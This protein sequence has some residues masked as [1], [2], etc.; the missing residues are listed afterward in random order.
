MSLPQNNIFFKGDTI[1]LE[2]QLFRDE[3]KKEYWNLTNHEIRFQLDSSPAIKKAT[4][5]VVGGS[6]EQIRILD[7][8]KGVF[9]VVITK[10][11]SENLSPKD[12]NFEIEITTPSGARYTVLQS[13]L[14]ILQDIVTWENK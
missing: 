3:E 1:E 2:F 4:A 8:L 5:N 13:S 9:L 14:R 10:E 12:Y 7:A 6:D 11:E